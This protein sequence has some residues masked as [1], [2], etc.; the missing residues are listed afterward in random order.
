[1]VFRFGD[2]GCEVLPQLFLKG[3]F[4]LIFLT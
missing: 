2:L 1:L 4:L 3:I